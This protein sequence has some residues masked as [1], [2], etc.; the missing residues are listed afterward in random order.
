MK[1]LE[2]NTQQSAVSTP[3]LVGMTAHSG[4]VGDKDDLFILEPTNQELST[5]QGVQTLYELA[6]LTGKSFMS[7]RPVQVD[8]NFN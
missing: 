3:L 8:L 1:A 4:V 5:E 6:K 7:W 2:V